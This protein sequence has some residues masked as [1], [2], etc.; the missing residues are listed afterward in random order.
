[1]VK[2]YD[3]V[4]KLYHETTYRKKKLEE[5]NQESGNKLILIKR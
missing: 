2:K 4:K 3:I 1:M 5:A